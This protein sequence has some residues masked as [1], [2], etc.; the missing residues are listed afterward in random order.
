VSDHLGSTRAV[1]DDAG[2]VLE[3]FDYYP[4]GLLMDERQYQQGAETTEKFS[5]KE[6]DDKTGFDYFGARYYSPGL[7]RWQSVDPKAGD[8]PAWSPYNYTL[9]NPINFVDPNGECVIPADPFCI[10]VA[11]GTTDALSSTWQG[12]KNLFTTNPI[13]TGEAFIN[14]AIN[15]EQTFASIKAGVNK[16]INMAT[17]GNPFL[18]GQVA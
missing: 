3:T 9:G 5:G 4:F 17:S 14:A 15:Y 16:R 7:G 13:E 8:Y 1:V 10:G 11:K 2:N 18:M 6:R 12:I